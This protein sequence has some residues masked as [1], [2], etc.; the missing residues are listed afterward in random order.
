MATHK[1][2][3]KGTHWNEEG[4]FL[5]ITAYFT[6]PSGICS[7]KRTDDNLYI[8]TGPSPTDLMSIPYQ[9]CDLGSTMWV[10]G[11]CF[12]SMGKNTASVRRYSKTLHGA[13]VG[14]RKEMTRP[15][16]V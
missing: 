8:Q 14:T 7:G 9:E 12:V 6:Q 15:G 2:F 16:V 4:D 3:S 11:K 1:S 5:V 10:K 13:S